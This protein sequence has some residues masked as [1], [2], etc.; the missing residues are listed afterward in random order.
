MFIFTVIK[1]LYYEF[2]NSDIHKH[3]RRGYKNQRYPLR[4]LYNSELLTI[5]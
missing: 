3:E 5:E 4:R 2:L 1:G